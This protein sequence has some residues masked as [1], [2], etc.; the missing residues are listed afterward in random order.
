VNEKVKKLK[1]K[2]CYREEVYKAETAYKSNNRTII[3]TI[4][5]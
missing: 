1:K 4:I 2:E 5:K 3:I